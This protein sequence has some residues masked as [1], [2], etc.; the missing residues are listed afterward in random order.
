VGSVPRSRRETSKF[1]CLHREVPVWRRTPVRKWTVVRILG[2][3]V[4]EKG[5]DREFGGLRGFGSQ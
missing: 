3:T 4:V 1:L 2:M 5:G